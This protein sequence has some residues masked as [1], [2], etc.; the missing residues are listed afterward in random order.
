MIEKHNILVADDEESVRNLLQKVLI[1]LGHLVATAANGEEVLAKIRHESFSLLIM[2]IRMP[3]LGGMEAFKILRLEYPHL[4]IIMMTAFSTVET[5]L[6]TMRLGAFDYLSKPFDLN[7]VKAITAKA[8]SSCAEPEKRDSPPLPSQRG[9][10]FIGTSP[11]MQEVF[12]TIGRVSAS[13]SSVLIQGESGTGKELVART[14]H[15]YSKRKAGPFVTVNCGAVPEG[16]LESEFFGHEK[17]SFT[18]AFTRKIGKFEYAD[19]GTIFLDEIGEMSPPLQVKLLRVLQERE[20]ERVGGNGRIS[21]D[22]RVIAATNQ[23]LKQ[24]MAHKTFRSD[25]FYRLNVVSI[26]IPPLKNRKE[27]IPLLAAYFRDKYCAKLSK[28]PKSLPEPVIRALEAYDWPGNVRELENALEHAIVMGG[29]QVILMEDL[30]QEILLRPEQETSDSTTLTRKPTPEQRADQNLTP[31]FPDSIL[32][33]AD[34]TPG[35]PEF[36]PGFSES[37]SSCLDPR[38]SLTV[39]PPGSL[40]QAVKA[41]E[42]ATI[43]KALRQTKG[44]KLQAAK[45]LAISRRALQYKIEAYGLDTEER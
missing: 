8:L 6:D 5:T 11:A 13:D 44:N 21:V 31:S 26:L 1:K 32:V 45:L 7:H 10:A 36:A 27:D 9:N 25:L 23:S 30:P 34:S 2:D 37:S 18:G 16:L 22:V 40:R 39:D 28:R 14:I 20:F 41:V 3:K 17:G 4:P 33:L 29:G 12:K 19:H 43:A 35:F 15:E 42:R 24:S 38:P